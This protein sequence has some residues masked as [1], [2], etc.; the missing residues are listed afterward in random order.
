MPIVRI[1]ANGCSTYYETISFEP[2]VRLYA[3]AILHETTLADNITQLEIT[4]TNIANYTEEEFKENLQ[5]TIL[6][7]NANLTADNILSIE[8]TKVETPSRRRTTDDV[9]AKVSF[10]FT[11]QQKDSVNMLLDAVVTEIDSDSNLEVSATCGGYSCLNGLTQCSG[12][13]CLFS[14]DN[15]NFGNNLK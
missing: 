11:E 4:A 1:K 10:I 13:A 6:Q 8:L 5:T 7:A 3:G 12:E 15:D 2:T 9:T 14:D